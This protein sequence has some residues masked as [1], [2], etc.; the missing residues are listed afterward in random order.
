MATFFRQ[1]GVDR[2]CF[3]L[4]L[5]D[6]AKAKAIVRG[7]PPAEFEG[8]GPTAEQAAAVARAADRFEVINGRAVAARDANG[9]PIPR[10][11]D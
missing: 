6:D 7:Q 2:K 10:G 4:T 5:V 9:I 3:R 8:P 11:H 1:L